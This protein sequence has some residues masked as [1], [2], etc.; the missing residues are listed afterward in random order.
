MIHYHGVPNSTKLNSWEV[1]RNRHVLVPWNLKNYVNLLA[2]SSSTFI[3]DNSAFTYWRSGKEIDDWSGYYEWVTQWFRHPNFR[4]CF[5]PD[6]IAGDEQENDKLLD[7]W[8]SELKGHGVPVWHMHESLERLELLCKDFNYVAIGSSGDY[9]TVGGYGWWERMN[10]AI[11]FVTDDN[12]FP[13]AKLHGLRML[14]WRVFSKLPLS[15]ADS[16]NVGINSGPKARKMKIPVDVMG[17]I[18]CRS[19]EQHNNCGTWEKTLEA[20]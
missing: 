3:L 20:V 11:D 1:F 16:C 19:I 15:S 12:G 5:I 10:E 6:V 18:M 2:D 4:F 9:A 14:N 17:E 13:L 7:E 8:P